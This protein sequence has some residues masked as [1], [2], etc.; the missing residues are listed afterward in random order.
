MSRYSGKIGF[1]YEDEVSPGEYEKII[2][3]KQYYGDYYKVQRQNRS[4]ESTND[5]L[6]IENEISIV[7]DPFS[8]DHMMDIV[9][10]TFLGKRLKVTH[11]T[12]DSPRILLNVG[13][14]Y[15]GPLP[16]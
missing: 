5:K 1:A 15:N 11:V 4:Q 14:V 2:T 13:E 16:G 6:V 8:T 9:Y 3:E 10:A 7:G 12:A